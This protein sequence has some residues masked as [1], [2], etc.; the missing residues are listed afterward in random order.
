MAFIKSV[1]ERQAPLPRKK[2]QKMTPPIVTVPTVLTALLPVPAVSLTLTTLQLI[3]TRFGSFGIQVECSGKTM[4]R[5]C[6]KSKENS[7]Q[8]LKTPEQEAILTH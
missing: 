2:I 3:M 7:L 6:L 8:A 1:K 4:W 5:V